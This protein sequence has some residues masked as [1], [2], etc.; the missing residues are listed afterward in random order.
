MVS[1]AAFGLNEISR[2]TLR[3]PM[4]KLKPANV[5]FWAAAPTLFARYSYSDSI[6]NQITNMWRIHKN[7]E[8]QGLGGTYKTTGIYKHHDNNG[9]FQDMAFTINT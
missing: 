9:H 2:L 7:R 4:F 3:S 6:E 8:A 5:L 1:V